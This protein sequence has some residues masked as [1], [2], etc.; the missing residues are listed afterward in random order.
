MTS[1]NESEVVDAMLPGKPSKLQVISDRTPNGHTWAGWE[2]QGAWENSG[3][4]T[5]QNSTVTSGEGAPLLVI[6]FSLWA[7]GGRSDQV[8]ATV[9]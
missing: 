1:S 5:R 2:F 6:E 3:E 9:Y 4:G 8:A 7:D